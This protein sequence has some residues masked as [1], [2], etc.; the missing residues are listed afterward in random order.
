MP[1][2]QSMMNART[3]HSKSANDRRD[4]WDVQTK[5]MI[6]RSR[7]PA[8]KNVELRLHSQSYLLAKANCFS[9]QSFQLHKSCPSLVLACIEMGNVPR[10]L[11]ASM[12]ANG[13]LTVQ[14]AM[15]RKCCQ[16]WNVHTCSQ[17]KLWCEQASFLVIKCL[18]SFAGRAVPAGEQ[19]LMWSVKKPPTASW[20]FHSHGP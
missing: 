3:K 20:A 6:V 14:F 10:Y 11:A 8:S 12:V 4:H 9:C 19:S 2:E 17:S 7:L 5:H 13:R 16:K 1:A 18:R 15:S